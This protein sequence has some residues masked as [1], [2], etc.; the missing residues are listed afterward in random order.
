[1]RLKRLTGTLTVGL[2]LALQ[3]RTGAVQCNSTCAEQT[4]CHMNRS[5]T[6]GYSLCQTQVC[7]GPSEN[8]NYEPGSDFIVTR[9][10]QV[11]WRCVWHQWNVDDN[12]EYSDQVL[13]G[14]L[15]LRLASM[16]CG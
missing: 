4:T 6:Y 16:E 10:Y 11:P 14:P 1:M 8:N 13:P 5:Y 9:C 2:A 12:A 15:A 7:D 3:S